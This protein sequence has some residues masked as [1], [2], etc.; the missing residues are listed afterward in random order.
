MPRRVWCSGSRTKLVVIVFLAVSC[1]SFLRLALT[2]ESHLFEIMRSE[3]R[4]QLWLFLKRG[5]ACN[6]ATT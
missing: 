3:F 1:L 4:Y 2:V 6:N 5:Q